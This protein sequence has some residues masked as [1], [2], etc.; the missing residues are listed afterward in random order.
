M[1]DDSLVTEA[2][3]G[4]T[5]AFDRLMLR[6]Q[7]LVCKVA[8][9]YVRE[10]QN[11]L[12]VTQNVFMKAYK[13]LDAVQAK[14]MFKPWLLR[15]TYNE[16]INWLR[17]HKRDASQEDIAEYTNAPSPDADQESE[18]LRREERKQILDGLE[19]LNTK[20]R[21]AVALRYAEGMRIREIADV[22]DCSEGMVKS[23]LFRGVRQIR[24]RVAKSA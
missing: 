4:E 18:T 14:G 16:S 22:M 9:N 20:Y 5:D 24:D 6:Y 17:K 10:R 19:K 13:N 8:L 1:T 21:L 23:L 15:I 12:D 3:G 2:R 7:K 11:A